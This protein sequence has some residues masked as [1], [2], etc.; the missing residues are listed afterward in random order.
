[1]HTLPARVP[2]ATA[3]IARCSSLTLSG[4]HSGRQSSAISSSSDVVLRY[5][6]VMLIIERMIVR[7]ALVPLSLLLAAA[8]DRDAHYVFV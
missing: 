4:S 6:M 7:G 3:N 2:L 1:M 5:R 8:F